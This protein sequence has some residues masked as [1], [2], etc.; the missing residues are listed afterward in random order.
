[1]YVPRDDLDRDR[2]SRKNRFRSAPRVSR[3][4]DV[5]EEEPSRASTN[6]NNRS[7][8][9][10]YMYA[11]SAGTSFLKA[12]SWR[13]N[14]VIVLMVEAAKVMK[15]VGVVLVMVIPVT[16]RRGRLQG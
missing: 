3:K 10:S 9:F 12:N 15:F 1:M 2:G 6:T 8:G 4:H 11:S 16:Q 5:T 7:T 14:V 13:H